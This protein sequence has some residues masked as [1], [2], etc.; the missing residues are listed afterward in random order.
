MQLSKFVSV[1]PRFSRAINLERDASNGSALDG[2]VITSTARRA[3]SRIS[4]TLIDSE[5]GRQRAWTLTGSYGSGKSAFALFLGSLL[6][7]PSDEVAETARAILREQDPEFHKHFTDKRHKNGFKKSGYCTVFVSG[8]T[9]PLLDRL[10]EACVRDMAR[11]RIFA[12]RVPEIAAL[13]IMAK[14]LKSGKQIDPTKVVSTLASISRGIRKSGRFAGILLIVDELGKFLEFAARVP[15]RGDIFVLQ[16]L[17]E[18]TC[19]STGLILITILH[20]AFER[21]A[22]GLRASMRDEW[23]KIQGRFEDIAFQEPPEQLLLL[24]GEAIKHADAIEI[25]ELKSQ[26][27]KYAEQAW[28]LELA[29]PG[30]SKRDFIEFL[31]RCTPLH[32]VTVLVLARLCKKFGQNQRSLFAFLVSRE[33]HSFLSFLE[34]GDRK[35]DFYRV[36]D[37]YNYISE[38]FGA[39]LSVG[40]NATRW[41]EV[42][43]ALDRMAKASS[44]QIQVIKTV[45]LLSAIGAFGKLKASP[46]VIKFGLGEAPRETHGAIARLLASSIL[47]K[48]KHS[49]DVALWQG[50]DVDLDARSREARR[51]LDSSLLSSKVTVKWQPRPLIAKRHSYQTGTLRYF[52]V[53]FVNCEEFWASLLPTEGADG[54]ILY[55]LPNSEADYGQLIG[56]ATS[57]TVR[58]RANVLIAIPKDIELLTETVRDLEVLSWI[59]TNTR[60]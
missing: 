20:Q 42:Q 17:A 28:D 31:V 22:A 49:G 18:S 27:R 19:E 26:T 10:V 56:L 45:G 29:P 59:T 23:A 40:E 36:A 4:E 15:E 47:V 60:S 51:H 21:Y 34:S 3:L 13:E 35:A 5:P 57:S 58:E 12:R 16:Q 54:L 50:S 38:N 24:I 11:H 30:L 6:S 43:S 37:L 53:K 7:N 55:C 41:A 25:R 46:E 1:A 44:S 48:R 9:E 2:Y 33:P 39:G 52:D 14:Q 32:P 8:S